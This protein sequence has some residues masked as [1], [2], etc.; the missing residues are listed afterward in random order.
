MK[1]LILTAAIVLGTLVSFAPLA[2]AAEGGGDGKGKRTPQDRIEMM[3]KELSLSEDQVAKLKPILEEDGKKMREIWQDSSMTQ[4]QK[5]EKITA[6]REASQAKVKPIL[7]K[8][9]FEKWTKLNA[10]RRQRKQQ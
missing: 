9:Q 4:E 7:T 3:K 10:E 1:K 6:L 5:R 2:Q 8:E